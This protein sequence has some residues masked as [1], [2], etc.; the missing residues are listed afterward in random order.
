MAFPE[1]GVAVGEAG[2]R[3]YRASYQV[4]G[5]RIFFPRL[6]MEGEPCDELALEEGAF[7]DALSWSAWFDLSARSWVLRGV[8]GE[9]L[10]FARDGPG[11]SR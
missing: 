5:G 10:V 3:R 7:T 2:C 4:E 11:G 1:G 8:R 6:E 9:R